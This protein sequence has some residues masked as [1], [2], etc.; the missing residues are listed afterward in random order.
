MYKTNTSDKLK[1]AIKEE[2]EAIKDYRQDAKKVDKKTAKLLRHIAKD[3]V[4]HK[5]ELGKR[6]KQITKARS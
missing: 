6:L 1:Y 3:E 5:K 2:A 4:H